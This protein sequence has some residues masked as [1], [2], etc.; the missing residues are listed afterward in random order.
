MKVR[1]KIGK[2]CPVSGIKELLQGGRDSWIDKQ[3]HEDSGERG[4]VEGP[5]SGS[6]RVVLSSSLS[7]CLALILAM[8]SH[9]IVEIQWDEVWCEERL[10]LALEK[11]RTGLDPASWPAQQTLCLFAIRCLHL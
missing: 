10:P 6:C 1:V 11:D 7:A 8:L 3:I 9:P 4:L 5:C 2:G